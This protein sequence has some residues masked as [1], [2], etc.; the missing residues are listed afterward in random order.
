MARKRLRDDPTVRLIRKHGYL[1]VQ[2]AVNFVVAW[3]WASTSTGNPNLSMAD[4]IEFWNA[5]TS[6]A[7][8]EREAFRDITGESTPAVFLERLASLGFVIDERPVPG[9]AVALI[10][11]LAS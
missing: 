5:N 6:S 9:D 7:Y 1:R 3:S 11:F 8:R 4:Y 2:R 10:P